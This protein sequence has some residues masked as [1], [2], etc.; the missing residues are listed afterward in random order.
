[1]AI[2][3]ML[4][5]ILVAFTVVPSFSAVHQSFISGVIGSFA[6]SILAFLL[7]VILWRI[8]RSVL[9]A[10]RAKDRADARR[11]EAERNDKNLLRECLAALTQLRALDYSL[12]EENPFSTSRERYFLELRISQAVSL[13]AND[14]LREEARFIDSLSENDDHLDYWVDRRYSRLRT[15]VDWLGRLVSLNPDGD[16]KEARPVNYADLH[17]SMNAYHAE[18]AQ[19]AEEHDIWLREERDRMAKEKAS[20][21]EESQV[22]NTEPATGE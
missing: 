6:G 9:I 3:V 4:V 10:E 16:V 15:A 22:A 7:A 18:R 11:S 5:L 20:S 13:I 12:R 17:E 2:V 19:Q 8:E 1:M 21:V 14:A